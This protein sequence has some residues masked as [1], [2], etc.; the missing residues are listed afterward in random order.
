MMHASVFLFCWLHFHESTVR[1]VLASLFCETN[2]INCSKQVLETFSARR[3]TSVNKRCSDLSKQLCVRSL[4]SIFQVRR[5]WILTAE[6]LVQCR[7][8][9]NEIREARCST[10]AGIFRVQFPLPITIISLLCTHLSLICHMRSLHQ[11]TNI[12]N[13]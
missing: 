4:T 13:A 1:T 5:Q 8:T 2:T 6:I 7:T 11:Q 10:G 9:S 3:S 12:K